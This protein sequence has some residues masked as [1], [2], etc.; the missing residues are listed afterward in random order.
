MIGVSWDDLRIAL[1]VAESGSLSKAG[2]KLG[3]NHATVLRHI[4]ALEKSMNVRL[5]LRHQRGYQLTDA[6]HLLVGELPDIEQR[7]HRL[8]TLLQSAEKNLSGPLSITVVNDYM[9]RITAALKAFR[10]I[11]PDVLLQIIAT[12]DILSLSSG[13][14]HVSLRMGPEPDD[15]DLIVKPL[16]SFHVHYYAAAS[17]WKKYGL[18]C[19]REEYNDHFWL[20]PS[21]RKR[22][23][24]YIRTMMPY[25]DETRIVY[26]SNSFLHLQMA[27]IEGMGIGPMAEDVVERY[28][29]LKRVGCENAWADDKVWYTYH[30]DIKHNSKVQALYSFLEQSL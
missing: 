1:Q 14:A 30:R 9:P 10:D 22:D 8:E 29:D 6:G 11:Y 24:P 16:N 7:F 4:N 5:F 15:T 23:I 13:D 19:C 28:T 3:I 21:G 26:Q 12:D 27:L 17:Y 2:Q 20:M 18:P 25:I